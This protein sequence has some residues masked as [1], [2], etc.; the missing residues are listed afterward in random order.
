MTWTD[1]AVSSID[2]VLNGE[3][4]RAPSQACEPNYLTLQRSSKRYRNAPFLCARVGFG[5]ISRKLSEFACGR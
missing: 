1:S 3:P 2:I 5:F 4:P